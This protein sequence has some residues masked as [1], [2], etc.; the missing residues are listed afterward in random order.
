MADIKKPTDIDEEDDDKKITS[1]EDE[2]GESGKK[3]TKKNDEG[4]GEDDDDADDSD[5]DEDEDEDDDE[6]VPPVRKHVAQHIITRQKKTIEK[7]RSKQDDDDSDDD[8]DNGDIDEDLDDDKKASK[9]IGQEVQKHLKPVIKA[10]ASEADENEL[11]D[12]F[13]NDPAAKKYEKR[14]RAY[15]QNEH[16]QGV[17]PSVIY[18]HLAF[19]KAAQTTDEKK[20][21]ADLEA[22]Q[23]KGAGSG[24]RTTKPK[25][26]VPSIDEMDDMD[27]KGFEKL[28]HEVRTGKFSKKEE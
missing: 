23:G 4:K 7:L 6:V 11:K 16:Y 9:A 2:D 27:D 1:K 20:K 14:I 18:H 3:T 25:G 22:S 8:D 17:P 26:D 13:T 28:Q 19:S 5:S 12:L 15:M 10:L 21:A 24:R